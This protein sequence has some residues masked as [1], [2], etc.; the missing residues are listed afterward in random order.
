M[1]LNVWNKNRDLNIFPL[2]IELFSK[3]IEHK[4]WE[5]TELFSK[6]NPKKSCGVLIS[7]ISKNSYSPLIFGSSYESIKIG[8]LYKFVLFSIVSKSMSTNIDNVF[9]GITNAS[10]KRKIGAKQFK[11]KAY[12][13]VSDH[14]NDGVISTYSQNSKLVIV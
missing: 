6:C 7:H 14:Y 13:Q 4:D 11:T 8:N 2:P 12:F 5:V 10:E 3:F 9:L 1:Y